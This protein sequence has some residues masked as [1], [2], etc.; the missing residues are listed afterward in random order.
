MDFGKYQRQ[1]NYYDYIESDAWKE[2]ADAA[3]QRAWYRC[4]VCNASEKNIS[5]HAHH[6]TYDR[7]GMERDDDLT[8]LCD[9]CHNIY[10][11]HGKIRQP[12][13]RTLPQI[14]PPSAEDQ[15][16]SLEEYILYLKCQDTSDDSTLIDMRFAELRLKDIEICSNIKKIADEQKAAIDE[17][18]YDLARKLTKDV[19]TLGQIRSDIC[20]QKESMSIR[21]PGAERI[22]I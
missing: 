2:K 15:I 6:R 16:K 3:K 11:A 17:G 7:L 4:Q 19:E 18:D 20:R 9:E 1:V 21:F 8:V 12:P 5:L 14:K 13:P 22:F 10:H